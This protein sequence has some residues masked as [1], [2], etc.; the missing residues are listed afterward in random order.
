MLYNFCTSYFIC[1]FTL[2]VFKFFK[3]IFFFFTILLV[4]LEHD[5]YNNSFSFVQLVLC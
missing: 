5:F 3:F 2:C 1:V 4:C